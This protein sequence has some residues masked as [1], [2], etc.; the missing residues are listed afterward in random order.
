MIGIGVNAFNRFSFRD[1]NAVSATQHSLLRVYTGIIAQ[2][3]QYLVHK[4]LLVPR[5]DAWLQ[6]ASTRP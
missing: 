1:W 3:L 6:R 4:G 2:C 5:G